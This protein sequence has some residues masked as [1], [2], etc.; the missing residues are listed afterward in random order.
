MRQFLL[1]NLVLPGYSRAAAA[2]HD[3]AKFTLPLDILK[4]AIDSLEEFPY[5]RH[6][7]DH[8][9]WEGPTMV[10]AGSRSE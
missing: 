4:P 10:I 3:K 6:S 1:T 2:H 7:P 5:D 8:P 9:V